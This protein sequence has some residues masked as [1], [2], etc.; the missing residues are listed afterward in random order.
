M[1]GGFGEIEESPEKADENK[2]LF[3]R[4]A[5]GFDEI[6][7]GDNRSKHTGSGALV[8]RFAEGFGKIEDNERKK[9]EEDA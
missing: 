1:A 6:Q 8:D 5:G 2:N 7:D 9:V 3:G 4:M